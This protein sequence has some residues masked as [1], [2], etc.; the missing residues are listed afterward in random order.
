MI[1]S[2]L[3]AIALAGTS[4]EKAETFAEEVGVDHATA[5]YRDLL[6]DPEIQAIHICSPNSTIMT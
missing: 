1:G 2:A 4:K 6:T 5:D 3:I